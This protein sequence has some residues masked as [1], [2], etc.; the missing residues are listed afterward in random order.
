M[1]LHHELAPSDGAKKDA[2]AELFVELAEALDQSGI[3]YRTRPK[4]KLG[5]DVPGPGRPEAEPLNLHCSYDGCI[6]VGWDLRNAD[7]GRPD[8]R[9]RSG[10]VRLEGR[11]VGAGP[12]RDC[13]RDRREVSGGAPGLSASRMTCTYLHSDVSREATSECRLL[14]SGGLRLTRPNARATA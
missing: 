8:V 10:R 7:D 9:A 13:A 6:G 2:M 14:A 1:T 4:A 12:G 5:L 3:G 11:P